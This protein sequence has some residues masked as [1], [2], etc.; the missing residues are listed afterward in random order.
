MLVPAMKKLSSTA[1]KEGKRAFLTTMDDADTSEYGGIQEEIP[2]S[3][4][5]RTAKP[6][7]DSAQRLC[8]NQKRDG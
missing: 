3:G 5:P 7:T 2:V 1:K 8:G 4:C 6:R